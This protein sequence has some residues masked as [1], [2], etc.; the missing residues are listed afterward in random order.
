MKGIC[1]N[2][3]LCLERLSAIH[4]QYEARPQQIQMLKEVDHII[5][6]HGALIVEA[7]TG[8]GK[9]LAYLI[10][11]LNHLD[12]L[13]KPVVISTSTI[14]LQE[15]LI[16]KDLPLALDVCG[17][18][19]VNIQLAK[20]KRNYVCYSKLIQ[21]RLSQQ[22]FFDEEEQS[23]LRQLMDWAEESDDGDLSHCSFHPQPQVW[24]QLS[25]HSDTC[26]RAN[27]SFPGQCFLTKARERLEQA[28]ILITNHHFL[29]SDLKL[30][31]E[32]HQLLPE[33]QTLVID[34]AHR[35]SEAGESCF[36]IR[37]SHSDII[38]LTRMIEQ[39]ISFCPAA[40][41]MDISHHVQQLQKLSL[42]FYENKL[43][44]LPEAFTLSSSLEEAIFPIT[45]ELIDLK[46]TFDAVAGH[47]RNKDEKSPPIW[48]K[49]SQ[50]CL[51]KANDLDTFANCDSKTYAYWG[52]HRKGHYNLYASPI[53]AGELLQKNL[54]D[55]ISQIVL[56]SATLATDKGLQYSAEKMGLPNAELAQIASPFNFSEQV[57]LN[58]SDDP[59]LLPQAEDYISYLSRYCLDLIL[60]TNGG[61]FVLFTS[62]AAMRAVYGQIQET[63]VDDHQLEVLCQ[64]IHHK[65]EIIR[66][67]EQS[68]RCV[69][70]GLDS[71]WTGIDIAGSH[72][73][74]VII[75]KLPFPVPNSPLNRAKMDQIERSGQN[76]FSDFMMPEAILKFKQGVG[77][78]IRS[79]SDQGIL[80]LLD[81]RICLKPYGRIF[82]KSIG[83]NIPTYKLEHRS[84]FQPK[85][86]EGLI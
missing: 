37:F 46:A 70:F 74:H 65:N 39:N 77:R 33:Y 73:R 15:Q 49:L 35:L 22:S 26:S 12:R 83:E 44:H 60:Q 10:P 36:S 9:T 32:S 72:L 64:N 23:E 57:K 50:L 3:S 21:N 45:G 13:P 53:A 54:F 68:S 85:P 40:Y 43:K 11:V 51:S 47:Y 6:H 7:G 18:D 5:E 86:C 19:Q 75:T 59:H 79:Q 81:P 55:H 58:I 8:V 16:N 76:S 24:N 52:E 67:F 62:D 38:Q 63:L 82:L 66:A 17:L 27:C 34:E 2:S 80:S 84:A 28:D 78:L 69:L 42:A 14:S 20:G 61:C 25:C 71:F 1:L 29:L 48:D 31:A 30:K 4:P 56:T 41:L